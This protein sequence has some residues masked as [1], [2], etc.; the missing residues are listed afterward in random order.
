MT[1]KNYTKTHRI[2][3]LKNE[4]IEIDP[5]MSLLKIKP[6]DDD[7]FCYFFIFVILSQCKTTVIVAH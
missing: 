2:L 3:E 6:F 5:L 7:K 4:I 1:K